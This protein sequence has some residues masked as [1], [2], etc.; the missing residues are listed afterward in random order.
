MITKTHTY[1][2]FFMLAALLL[3]ACTPASAPATNS[4]STP[5]APTDTPDE[6]VMP[7]N[8][9]TDEPEGP[10][11]TDWLSGLDPETVLLQLD[12]EPT[13]FRREAFLPFGRF[14][15]FTLYADGTLVYIKAGETFEQQAI[16]LV[17]LSP[18]ETLEMIE[19]VMAMGFENLED[20]LDFC[21]V[22]ADGTEV[23]IADDAYTVLRGVVGSGETREI[24]IY[25]D[26]ANDPKAFAAVRGFFSTY[27]HPNASLYM[28]DQ[29]TLFVNRLNVAIEAPIREWPLEPELVT[30]LAFNQFDMSVIV[31]EGQTLD[32]FLASFPA[33]VSSF[34]FEVEG[35]TY[36]MYTVPWLPKSEYSAQIEAAFPASSGG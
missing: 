4:P 9:P 14:P 5:A 30:G 7:T 35:R 18:E 28:P 21:H 25:S 19:K 13:F 16:E 1:L 22:Q 27:S 33:A 2:L 3:A 24:K 23:C 8:Q 6:V 31:L 15:V 36:E 26:F 17:Q 29:I 11:T 12:Y 34:F 20:H 32:T 10:L